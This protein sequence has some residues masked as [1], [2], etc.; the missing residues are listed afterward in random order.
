MF[1]HF[2]EGINIMQL[3]YIIFGLSIASLSYSVIRDTWQL[4]LKSW[5]NAK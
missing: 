4:W 3:V 2:K 5:R 1:I